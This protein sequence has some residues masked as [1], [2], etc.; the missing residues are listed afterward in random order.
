M[1]HDPNGEEISGTFHEKQL[2]KT[3]QTEFRVEKIIKRKGE[4]LYVKWKGYD[5]LFNSWIDK[6]DVVQS[7]SYHIK[8]SEYFPKSYERFDRNISVRLDL[9]NYTTKVDL[10]GTT[11]V[12]TSNL[13]AKSD[14][15]SLKAKVDKIDVGKL[16]IVPTDL[17]KISNVV[18]NDVVKKTVYDKLVTKVNAINSSKFV[19][20]TQCDTDKSGLEKKINDANKKISDISGLVKKSDYYAK[21]SEI[22]G[23]IL[24]IFVLATTTTLTAVGK[25]ILNVSNVV[26]K[27]DYDA[28]TSVIEGKYFTTSDYNKFTRDILDAK[29]KEQELVDKSAIAGFTSN[30]DLKIKVATLATKV[31]LKAEQDKIVKLQA[32]DLSYFC[33]ES[34]FEGDGTRHYLVFQSIFR[35]FKKIDNTDHISE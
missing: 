8:I 26:K 3:N 14:L 19:L 13:A 32:L 4:R 30:A 31:E 22:E 16:N 20:K 12:D 2:Q 34:H 11:G 17:S 33:S 6:K 5:N 35:Y 1:C 7:F 9:S 10:T 21:V 18:N 27:T 25:K 24:S 23:K 15:A 28:K 29:L